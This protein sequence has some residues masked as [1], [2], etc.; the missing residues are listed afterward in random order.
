MGNDISIIRE[1]ARASVN[2]IL[3]QHY[4]EIIID[5]YDLNVQWIR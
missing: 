2:L 3:A 4:A 5:S 1:Q